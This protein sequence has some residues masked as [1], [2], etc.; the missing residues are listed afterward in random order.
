M[1]LLTLYYSM[2]SILS[3]RLDGI[4]PNHLNSRN[5][6]C[7]KRHMLKRYVDYFKYRDC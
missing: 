6:F 1:H 3:T 2:I 7:Y 4:D 5:V